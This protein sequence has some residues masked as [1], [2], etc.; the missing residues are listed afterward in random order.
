MSKEKQKKKTN[1]EKLE[2]MELDV[3]NYKALE[4]GLI[5]ENLM[6]PVS[7]K[8]KKKRSDT[9]KEKNSSDEDRDTEMASLSKKCGFLV[10]SIIGVMYL[11]KEY[12]YPDAVPPTLAP[13]MPPTPS[14]MPTV[15]P[16]SVMSALPPDAVASVGAAAY[17]LASNVTS[18]IASTLTSTFAPIAAEEKADAG[19]DEDADLNGTMPEWVEADG[20]ENELPVERVGRRLEGLGEA[21]ER[22]DD[23]GEPQTSTAHRAEPVLSSV[24]HAGASFFSKASELAQGALALADEVASANPIVSAVNSAANGIQGFFSDRGVSAAAPVAPA[25][26]TAQE[27]VTNAKTP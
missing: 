10:L 8:N 27:A 15:S 21:D 22:A 1:L 25:F 6:D 2:A 16:S 5:E 17:M 3:P 23:L 14:G 4:Q 26:A 18:N 19:I 24:W 11:L 7:N 13:T 12:V 20:E 9:K